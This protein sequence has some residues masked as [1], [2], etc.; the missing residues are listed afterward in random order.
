MP[1]RLGPSLWRRAG[2]VLEIFASVAGLFVAAA[3]LGV[4]VA[5]HLPPK[6]VTPVLALGMWG[7]VLVGW[8]LLK[9]S[10][11]SYRD[12]GLRRPASWLKTIGWAA[13]AVAIGDLGAFAI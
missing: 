5:P 11:S 9:L 3:S 1:A 7:A 10:K 12:L 8:L 13:F 2:A 4:L 6:V